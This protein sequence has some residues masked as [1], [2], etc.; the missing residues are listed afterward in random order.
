MDDRGRPVTPSSSAAERPRGTAPRSFHVRPGSRGLGRCFAVVWQ[1]SAS[2][3]R[4]DGLTSRGTAQR[5]LRR[6]LSHRSSRAAAISNP[7]CRGTAVEGRSRDDPT[8][9]CRGTATEPAVVL[10]EGSIPVARHWARAEWR[11][12]SSISNPIPCR[13]DPPRYDRHPRPRPSDTE[14]RGRST[15]SAPPCPRVEARTSTRRSRGSGR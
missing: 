4:A 1:K 11:R 14:L 6:P 13:A 7:N 2:F 9:T 12:E 15:M 3:V 8:P 5:A 10:G